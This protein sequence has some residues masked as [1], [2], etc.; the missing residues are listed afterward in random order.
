MESS[1]MVKES[2]EGRD[3]SGKS[4]HGGPENPLHQAVKVR[5]GL[6]WRPEDVGD[7]RAMVYLPRRTSHRV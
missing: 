4:L 3:I 5:P 7:A 1:F 6:C 2:I